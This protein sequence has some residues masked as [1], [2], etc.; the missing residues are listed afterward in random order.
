MGL[1][2]C[3]YLKFRTTSTTKT[4][5][6][7]WHMHESLPKLLFPNWRENL[8][9]T[10]KT[11]YESLKQLRGFR[12]STTPTIS[13]EKLKPGGVQKKRSQNILG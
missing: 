11:Y 4:A 13:R 7:Y 9:G 8:Y 10:Y 1:P 3:C 5:Q 6:V 2:D 12:S